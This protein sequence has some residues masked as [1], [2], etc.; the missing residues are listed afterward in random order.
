M[1]GTTTFPDF[2]VVALCS[3]R[4]RIFLFWTVNLCGQFALSTKRYNRVQ[5][6]V[7]IYKS[8]EA[9]SVA[10][11]FTF[12]GCL[13]LTIQYKILI[14]KN[15]LWTHGLR[16]PREEMAFTAQ[17]K[18]HSHSQI[19]RYGGSIFC[20]PHRPN[21]SDIFDFCLYWVSVVGA[22]YGLLNFGFQQ[23]FQ[24]II[25]LNYQN[26]TKKTCLLTYLSH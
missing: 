21:F 9:W 7:R 13:L 14:V 5:T 17:P 1:Q 12:V 3:R 4:I 8:T 16:M 20:L 2:R 25:W 15:G 24:K 10:K 6:I 22:W 11:T 19:F 23:Y 26:C 18:I